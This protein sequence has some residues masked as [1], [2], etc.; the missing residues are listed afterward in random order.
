MKVSRLSL[1]FFSRSPT[2]L[3]MYERRAGE[4]SSG[5]A[6]EAREYKVYEAQFSCAVSSTHV[7]GHSSRTA[8]FYIHHS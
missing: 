3:E 7:G 1:R 2:M 8:R 6:V 4:H 5:T